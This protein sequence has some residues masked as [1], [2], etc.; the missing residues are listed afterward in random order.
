MASICDGLCGADKLFL[1]DI[2]PARE[3]QSQRQRTDAPHA[4]MSAGQSDVAFEADLRCWWSVVCGSKT[5][6]W[7]LTMGAGD[8][9]KVL[10]RGAKT[11]RARTEHRHHRAQARQHSS[12]LGGVTFGQGAIRRDEPMARHTS[13]CVGGP[14]EFLD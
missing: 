6:G 10:T 14:A 2:Y 8:I 7:V 3:N 13:I 5:G 11:S 12:R 9:N 4:V 1:T